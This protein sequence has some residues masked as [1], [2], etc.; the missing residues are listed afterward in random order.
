MDELRNSVQNASYENKDPLLIYKIESYDLFKN[1]VEAMNKKAA[2]ILMRARIPMPE[3]SEQDKKGLQ[4][5]Q[6][7]PEKRTDMS[8][9]RTQKDDVLE[10]TRRQ[11]QAASASSASQSAASQAKPE[12]YRAEKKIGRNDPC[13]CGSGKKYKNCHGKGL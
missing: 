5:R 11:Q 6:A 10:D 9:Y 13:P 1:M 2:A 12:P 7:A 3:S 8:K 4:V